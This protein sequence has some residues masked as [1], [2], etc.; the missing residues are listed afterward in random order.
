MRPAEEVDAS[1]LLARY[2]QRGT[3]EKDFGDWN[4]ALALSLSS[5]P[6]TK[7]HYRGRV[8]HDDFTEPDSFAANEA[9]LLMSLLAANL[10][11]RAICHAGGMEG[12]ALLSAGRV[13]NRG[14]SLA[15]DG[16]ASP[17][18]HS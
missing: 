16:G 14:G 11:W 4:Q 3:A 12:W 2:R 18:S 7:T 13:S 1:A 8:L 6:R 10:I 15:V 17:V 9:R 5:T